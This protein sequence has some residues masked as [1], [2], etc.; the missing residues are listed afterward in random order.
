MEQKNIDI[1]IEKIKNK[2][3]FGNVV[4]IIFFA[5][6]FYII[7]LIFMNKVNIDNIEIKNKNNLVDFEKAYPLPE[8]NLRGRNMTKLENK[9]DKNDK[10]DKK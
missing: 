5:L 4:K 2:I 9:N 7:L 10:N 1:L 8:K 6:L 3:T